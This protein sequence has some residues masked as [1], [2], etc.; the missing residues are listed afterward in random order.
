MPVSPY[1]FQGGEFYGPTG[2]AVGG[3]SVYVGDSVNQRLQKFDALGNFQQ[4][5]GKDVSTG[6][7]TGYEVCTVAANCKA[8]END[9]LAASWT[10]RTGSP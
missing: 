1:G 9:G 8:A 3:G 5:W 10:R 4:A 6:G 7:G 2:I